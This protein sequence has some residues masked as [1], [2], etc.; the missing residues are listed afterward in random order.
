MKQT[1]KKMMIPS[2]IRIRRRSNGQAIAL[3]LEDAAA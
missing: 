3:W 2:L 1:T